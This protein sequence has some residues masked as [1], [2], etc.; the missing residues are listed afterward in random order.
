MRT[1]VDTGASFSCVALSFIKSLRLENSI[2]KATDRRKLFSADGKQMKIVGSILLSLNIHG[3][4]IPFNFYVLETLCH[5][6]LVGLDFLNRTKA[7]LD[8]ADRTLTLYD[9][10]VGLNIIKSREA[11]VRT[12]DAVLIP[13]KSESILPVSVSSNF[14]NDLALIDPS[15]TLSGKGLALARALVI[16]MKNRTV[17]KLLN[18]TEAPI[19]LKKR[20]TI[21][22]IEKAMLDSVNV[23]Q[24]KPS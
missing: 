12:I 6:I 23:I 22:V 9:D 1:L 5:D 16:T 21:G 19:F 15:V 13:P 14:N 7:K 20:S 3:L 11:L 18:P 8:L 24:E 17:C 2:V 4:I 10:L